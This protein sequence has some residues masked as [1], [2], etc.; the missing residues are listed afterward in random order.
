MGVSLYV[1]WKIFFENQL[2]HTVAICLLIKKDLK[3]LAHP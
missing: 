3:L 1:H 2:G